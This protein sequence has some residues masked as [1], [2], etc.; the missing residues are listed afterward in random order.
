MAGR[1]PNGRSSIYLGADGRWPG[2]VTMG[3]KDNG[4]PD[5]RHV[6]AKTEAGVTKKVR[7]LE[8]QRGAG[9]VAAAGRTPSVA[10]WLRHWLDNIA[11]RS[12]RPRTIEGYRSKIERHVVPGI[13]NHRLDRLL[14]EHL[15]QLYVTLAAKGLAPASVLQVHRIISRS[16]K[17][18][19][20]RGRL[21][22]NVATL[23]EAP[24]AQPREIQPLTPHQ[25]R[26]LI[27]VSAGRG[28]SAR[29]SVALALGLRQGEALGLC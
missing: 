27:D 10:D 23:V 19:L 26:T 5:R 11:S 12:L 9:A 28:N 1:K 17:I 3:V 22:R 13:G 2:R 21:A 14:P 6:A 25:A 4:Q 20:Q 15:E 7:Q 24:R 8:Q 29:W 18:A 16:L